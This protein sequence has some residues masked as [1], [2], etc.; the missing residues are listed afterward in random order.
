MALL[1]FQGLHYTIGGAKLFT[2]V[3]LQLEP[4]DRLCLVGRNG[5]GKSTL[6]GLMSGRLS[7]D[8]GEVS[9]QQ[10]LRIAGLDQA[11]PPGADA[12]A[13]ESA[14]AAFPSNDD[15][16]DQELRARRYLSKLDVDAEEHF[17]TL[18][19]GN[20]RRVMLAGALASEPDLLLLDEPPNH[21]D[22]E[23]IS[24][25]EDELPRHR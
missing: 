13:L 12:T 14:V 1:G 16:H 2:G 20:R 24:W 5:A 9:R 15:P 21:L 18:S 7:A 6:L 8:K 25:L 19:G 10:G 3:G 17:A 23:T 11:L 22:I 4:G